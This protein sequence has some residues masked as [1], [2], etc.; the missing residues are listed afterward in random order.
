MQI[1]YNSNGK[2]KKYPHHQDILIQGGAEITIPEEESG[3][4]KQ[5][6]ANSK[7]KSIRFRTEK[8]DLEKCQI[9][10]AAVSPKRFFKLSIRLTEPYVYNLQEIQDKIACAFLNLPRGLARGTVLDDIPGNI[11]SKNVVGMEDYFPNPSR[12]TFELA[13]L[14]GCDE[15]KKPSKKKTFDYWVFDQKMLNEGFVLT[16]GNEEG[17]QFIRKIEIGS[18]PEGEDIVTAYVRP[19]FCEEYVI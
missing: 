4:P 14:I 8:V 9:W 15:A 18:L 19:W 7:P 13:E 1:L 10:S 6:I 3:C 16:V 5:R 17:T 12:L 2:R 11:I